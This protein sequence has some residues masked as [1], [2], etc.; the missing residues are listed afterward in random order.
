MKK[1]AKGLNTPGAVL[2]D[3]F[4]TPVARRVFVYETTGAP[5]DLG[6]GRLVRGMR[7]SI[8]KCGKM[9]SR[10]ARVLRLTVS[11]RRSMRPVSPF[12]RII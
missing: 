1:C 7:V 11:V 6:V 10:N 5:I 8:R 2:S 12:V 3:D 9:E 4:T